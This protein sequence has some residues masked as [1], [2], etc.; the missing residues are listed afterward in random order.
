MVDKLSRATLTETVYDISQAASPAEDREA[1]DIAVDKFSFALIMALHAAR[2]KGWRGWNRSSECPA[3]RLVDLLHKAVDDGN[4]LKIG[5]YAMMLHARSISNTRT[6]GAQSEVTEL[7]NQIDAL[8]KKEQ[9]LSVGTDLDNITKEELL[10]VLQH[11]IQD[12]DSKRRTLLQQIN[13][14]K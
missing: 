11:R 8:I 9:E 6:A 13:A 7:S 12:I 2:E 14:L 3:T 1:C 4:V 10:R 5:T